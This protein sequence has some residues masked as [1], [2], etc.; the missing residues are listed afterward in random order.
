MPP[1]AWSG[2]RPKTQRRLFKAMRGKALFWLTKAYKREIGVLSAGIM[3]ELKGAGD[4]ATIRETIGRRLAEH[5]ERLRM[6]GIGVREI[7]DAMVRDLK[8]MHELV[9]ETNPNRKGLMKSLQNKPL[10]DVLNEM[11]QYREQMQAAQ[12]QKDAA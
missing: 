12:A 4:S 7:G 3:H 5:F 11:K 10:E 9:A 2:I 1:S 8:E 6:K